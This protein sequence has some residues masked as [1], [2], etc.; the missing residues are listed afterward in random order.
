MSDLSKDEIAKKI[1]NDKRRTLIR[2]LGD[3]DS[4]TRYNELERESRQRY[5]NFNFSTYLGQ[6][7]GLYDKKEEDGNRSYYKL[8]RTGRAAYRMINT[9]DHT[10]EGSVPDKVGVSASYKLI[11]EDE[12]FD[13]ASVIH[14]LEG[15]DLLNKKDGQRFYLRWNEIEARIDVDSTGYFEIDIKVSREQTF[16]DDNWEFLETE[17][18]ISEYADTIMDFIR[19]LIFFYICQEHERPRLE[20]RDY[21]EIRI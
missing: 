9:L 15:C 8:N 21:N 1:A 7:E 11:L 10:Q 4:W 13:N 3:R 16:W 6:I 17:N 18:N 5:G 14:R 12:E 19:N 2:I 20:R